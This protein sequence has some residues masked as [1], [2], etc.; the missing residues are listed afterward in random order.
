VRRAGALARKF[1]HPTGAISLL[2][3]NSRYI[4]VKGA[5]GFGAFNSWARFYFLVQE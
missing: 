4:I 3:I 1:D 2:T 5:T